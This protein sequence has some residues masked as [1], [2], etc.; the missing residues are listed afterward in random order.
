[1]KALELFAGAGG[2][3]LGTANA[4]FRHVVLVEWDPH[5]CSTLRSNFAGTNVLQTDVRLMK[6]SDYGGDIALISGGPPCQPFSIG[7]KHQAWDD[8]R[9]MFPEAIRAVAEVRPKAF[10][11]ENVKG[12]SRQAFSAYLE[13]ILLQLTYPSLNRK[14]NEAWAEHLTRLEQHHSGTGGRHPE[15][16]VFSP[17]VLNAADYGV[18]QKRERIFFVGFRADVNAPWRFPEPTHSEESL[19]IAKWITG[20]YWENAGVSPTQERPDDKILLRLKMRMTNIQ[21]R[22]PWRTLR[23]AISDLPDPSSGAAQVIHN[24][25]LQ[26]G[27]KPYP[28]HSGS[29]ID[30]PSKTLKAGDHGVPGGENMI[31]LPGQRYRYLTVRESARVQTFHDH[32]LF[33]GSWTEAMRQLGN[34]VPV[35]LATTMASSIH[36]ALAGQGTLDVG[37]CYA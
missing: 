32:Y 23:D 14:P 27:A 6:Y 12:L 29:I 19:L 16:K 35:A 34:A 37:K 7:G 24:H 22:K 5:A 30:E 3:A 2:L 33:V 8:H 25:I 9:D 11:F 20:E 31:V 21:A 17:R 26:A 15:Y 13:Y 28:G 4:G 36:M 1:M 18:P 10:L